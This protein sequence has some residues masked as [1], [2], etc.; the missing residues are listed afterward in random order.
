[1][2]YAALAGCLLVVYHYANMLASAPVVPLHTAIGT[3]RVSERAAKNY[4]AAIAFMKEKKARGETVMVLPEDTMLYVLSGTRAPTRVN[5][6]LP[7]FLAPGNMTEELFR[8][9]GEKN[10]RYLVWSN[11]RFPQYGAPIFGQDF[12]QELARY[13]TS[14]F[15]PVGLLVPPDETGRGQTFMVWERESPAARP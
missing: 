11:R 8:Q 10:V 2:E 12:N 1:L 6:F 3:F 14:R 13:L 4:Q 9:I 7:G 5:E 15:K